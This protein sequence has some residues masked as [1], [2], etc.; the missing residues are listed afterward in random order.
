MISNTT[1]GESG[2]GFSS[3]AEAGLHGKQVKTRNQE[4]SITEGGESR[5]HLG[6]VFVRP[7]LAVLLLITALSP[8]PLLAQ[9]EGAKPAP[10][11]SRYLLV[12]ETSRSMQRR[13]DAV[14]QLVQDMLK[15]GLAGQMRTGDTLGVWTYNDSLYAGRF[16]LQKWSPQAQ[17]DITLRAVTFLKDQK[18]EKAASFD[19]VQPALNHIIE[20]STLLTIILISSGD[21]KI[22]GTRFDDSLNGFYQKWH[23]QQQKARMPFVTVLRAQDGKL[24]DFT[25]NTPPFP[26]QMPHLSQERPPEETIQ[27]KL[28]EAV[29]SAPAPQ[30]L[31]I[32][33]KKPQPEKA[34][35]PLPEATPAAKSVAA[36]SG[37]TPPPVQVA[38]P[39]VP[40]AAPAKPPVDLAPKT[41]PVPAP[42][43]EASVVAAPENATRPITPASAKLAAASAPQ[44]PAPEPKPAVL[45]VAKPVAVPV[46]ETKPAP[47]PQPVSEPRVELAKAPEPKAAPLVSPKA[48]AALAPAATGE[49]PSGAR[50]ASSTASPH[51]ISPAQTAAAVPAQT[52]ARNATIWIAGLVLAAAAIGLAL[53]LLRRSRATAGASLITQSFERKNKP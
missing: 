36:K 48:N 28:L 30:S 14:L 23:D 32:S 47:A 46:P 34:A 31:I 24:A 41:S 9:A 37:A 8:H 2:T 12:V 53:V 40:P 35:A 22:H 51:P 43:P 5:M 27:T 7:L 50:S 1:T 18:Y 33:G 29:R 15:S 4:L 16:P 13:S 11:P 44:S 42:V 17:S 38:K 10:A 20:D 45:E 26:V 39:E 25:A 49:V 21:E 19:Q 3:G 52:M 6:S